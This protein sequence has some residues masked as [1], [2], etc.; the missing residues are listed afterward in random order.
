MSNNE[1]INNDKENNLVIKEDIEEQDKIEQMEKDEIDEKIEFKDK[2]IYVFKA[3]GAI[4]SSII[5][6]FGYF[7]VLSLG[8]T[9]IYLISFRRHYNPNVNLSYNYNFIPLLNISFSLSAPIGSYFEN[10]FGGKKTIILSNAIL[11]FSFII[12]Y[13][14]RSIYLDYILM[15]INGFGMAAG[16]NITKKN[17]I[18]F[19]PKRKSL[20]LGIINLFPNFFSLILIMYN[21]VFVVNYKQ[22]LPSTVQIYYSESVFMNYQTLIIYE[23]GILFFTGLLACILYFKND[24]KERAK[25]GFNEKKNENENENKDEKNEIIKNKKIHKKIKIKEA[26]NNK[27]ISKL[28]LMVLLFCPT[29]N[30][31]TNILRMDQYYYFMFG[32]LYNI[33]GCIF[34][35]IFGILGDCI[36]F[37]ILF[38]ILAVLSTLTSLVY[39]SY[40]EGEF[41]LFFETVLV[42]LIYNGFIIIFDTHIMNVF[43]A[44]NYID[45]WA[46]IRAP[47]GITHLF[48]IILNC[49]LDI[50]SPGY[51]IVYGISSLGSLISLLIGI[52]E[53][54]DKFNYEN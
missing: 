7:S 53:G 8:Y 35:L 28:M 6:T 39:I 23:I 15:I 11:C 27:R 19:F 31:I 47:E 16:F 18:S 36:R 13:F 52:C 51:K 49:I 17:A 48:G 42:S 43:G 24:P 37:K 20:I 3:I 2:L 44:E 26:L 22:E 14:S 46:Y 38:A 21:E 25:L 32:G 54:E 41:I 10:R 5:Q 29:I 33:A 40:F 12:M 1:I 4:I 9:T 45:I 34:S 30:L 50:N